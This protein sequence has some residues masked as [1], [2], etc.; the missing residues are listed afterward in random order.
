[1][2]KFNSNKIAEPQ[3]ILCKYSASNALHKVLPYGLVNFM[4]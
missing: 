4:I 1:M 2:I 3:P